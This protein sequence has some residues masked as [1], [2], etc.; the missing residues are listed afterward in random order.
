[1]WTMIIVILILILIFAIFGWALKYKEAYW[2]ISGFS[3]R[4]EEEQKEL[5]KN[6]YPQKIGTL[7]FIV[8]AGMLILL[9]LAFTSFAFSFE[10]IFA[11]MFIGLTGGMIYLTKFDVPHKRKKSALIG[12]ITSI[13]VIA[14]VAG[15]FTAG[16]Q[17][18]E[19]QFKQDSFEITGYYGD[20]WAYE[21]IQEI[22]LLEEMPKVTIRTNGFGLPTLSKGHFKVK[23]YGSSLLFIHHNSPPY[24][25]IKA[26]EDN[27][28]INS[29]NPEETEKWHKQLIERSM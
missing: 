17:D 24:L 6:G 2:L 23:E 28:F 18:F 12:I 13:A 21:N 27:V 5:I 20:E 4:P 15:V 10:I 7:F 14:I 8:A 26:G 16:Y 11:F 3:N 29:K 1:M 25:Y 9:P 22:A 19:I